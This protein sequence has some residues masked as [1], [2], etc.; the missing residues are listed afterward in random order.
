M[1]LRTPTPQLLF[2]G[3][4]GLSG[5]TS[6]DRGSGEKKC[7]REKSVIPLPGHLSGGEEPPSHWVHQSPGPKQHRYPVLPGEGP[8][9]GVIHDPDL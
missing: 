9:G 1:F 5:F 8:E 3:V 7:G 4:F 2:H 6:G